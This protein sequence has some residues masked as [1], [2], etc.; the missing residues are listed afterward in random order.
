MT[1]SLMTS[2]HSPGHS[3]ESS[4]ERSSGSSSEQ[5]A[6]KHS[7]K[8]SSE[9]DASTI[10]LPRL[11]LSEG[12]ARRVIL[13]AIVVA[14]GLISSIPFL[15]GFVAYFDAQDLAFHLFRIEGLAQGLQNGEFPVRI[16]TAQINGYGYPVS[17]CYGDLLLYPAA[18]LRCLGVDIITAYCIFI[19]VASITTSSVS[20]LCFS[21]MFS[22]VRIGIFAAAIWTLAPYRIMDVFYRAALGEHLALIGF[23]L[24]AYGIY[25]I[26]STKPENIKKPGWLWC[27]IGASIVVYSHILSTFMVLVVAIPAVIIELVMNHRAKVVKDILLALLVTLLLTAAFTVPFI[28]FMTSEDLVVNARSHDSEWSGFVQTGPELYRMIALFPSYLSLDSVVEGVD[29]GSDEIKMPMSFGWC[30]LLCGVLF[31]IAL[32]VCRRDLDDNKGLVIVGGA[33][34]VGALILAFMVSEFF[35]WSAIS[36]SEMLRQILYPFAKL[37]FT[38]RFMGAASFLFLISGCCGLVLLRRMSVSAADIATCAIVLL[39]V[40]EIVMASVSTM[41]SNPPASP[42]KIFSDLGVGMKEYMPTFEGETTLDGLIYPQGD[43]DV[44]PFEKQ[45]SSIRIRFSSGADGASM[46]IPMMYYSNYEIVESQTEGGMCTLS[47]GSNGLIQVNV[48]PDTSGAIRIAFVTPLSWTIALWISWLTAAACIFVLLW[49][50]LRRIPI[51]TRH[52]LT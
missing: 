37:Q 38:W 22:S 46:I 17:I 24:I 5:G 49:P 36:E 8:R 32:I 12:G 26:F 33:S 7:S 15:F 44:S 1:S 48:P 10:K 18:I 2:E 20:Y 6:S 16:Q 42:E 9:Q 34:L 27:A 39:A 14:I 43:L 50:R 19:V 40:V 3:S 11:K 41:S 52:R 35:P 4:S 29:A 45:G 21:R 30:V 23:P 47:K 31:V 25:L 51:A 13:A 28:D